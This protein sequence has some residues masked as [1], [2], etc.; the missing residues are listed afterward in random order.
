MSKT[1]LLQSSSK[2]WMKYDNYYPHPCK[3]FTYLLFKLT[4][5]VTLAPWKRSKRVNEDLAHSP[6]FFTG[7]E[8]LNVMVRAKFYEYCAICVINMFKIYN[9]SQ[10]YTTANRYLCSRA[11]NIQVTNLFVAQRSSPITKVLPNSQRKS[12]FQNSEERLLRIPQN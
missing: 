10:I 11:F 2:D 4:N 3:S 8:R 12:A 9:P 7:D 6:Y 1:R 5:A